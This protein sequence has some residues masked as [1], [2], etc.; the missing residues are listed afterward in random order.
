MKSISSAEKLAID[1][2]FTLCGGFNPL[3][4]TDTGKCVIP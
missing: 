1:I 2:D 4:S 3:L